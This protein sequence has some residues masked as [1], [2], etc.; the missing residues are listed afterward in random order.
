MKKLLSILVLGLLSSVN[1]YADKKFLVCS[2]DNRNIE[3][4]VK[5]FLTSINLDD[6]FLMIN[7]KK[8]NIISVHDDETM[9]IYCNKNLYSQLL[10]I[11]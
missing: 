4:G 6:N 11:H 1:A 5:E 2:H 8:F 10:S 9:E 3:R 7:Y